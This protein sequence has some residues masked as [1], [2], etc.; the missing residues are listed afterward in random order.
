MRTKLA[1]IFSSLII[2]NSIAGVTPL[3]QG[4]I[5]SDVVGKMNELID[6]PIAKLGGV[7]VAFLLVTVIAAFIFQIIRL[8][9]TPDFPLL[10]EELMRNIG[11]LSAVLIAIGF[12]TTMGFSWIMS[13]VRRKD[14][15]I[16]ADVLTGNEINVTQWNSLLGDYKWLVNIFFGFAAMTMLIAFIFEIVNLST[17]AGNPNARAKSV[18]SLLT[19]GIATALLG[20][21]TLIISTLN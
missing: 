6:G 3:A 9:F 21:L 12:M 7:L 8:S 5:N 14:G 19:T 2:W 20:S 16:S 10:R 13:L 18:R 4:I 15:D 1:G 11:G 17:H